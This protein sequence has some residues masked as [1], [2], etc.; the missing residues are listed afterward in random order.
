MQQVSAELVEWLQNEIGRGCRPEV[1]IES[2]IKAGYEADFARNVINASFASLEALE[3]KRPNV[4]GANLEGTLKINTDPLPGNFIKTSDRDVQ[5]LL[6]MQSP[7]IMLF[8]GLLSDEECDG[9]IEFSR[10]KMARSHVVDSDAGGTREDEARTSTG[11]AFQRGETALH[12]RIEK[13]ISELLGWPVEHGE[14][15]QILHYNI[16]GEY[17]PHYDYFHH[18]RP[19]EAEQ[20][21]TGGQRIATLVMY[22]NDVEAGGGTIFPELGLETMPKKG[23]AI[24][25]AYG[26]M[27]GTLDSRSLHGGAPVERGEKW[28]ATKWIRQ[29]PY[30][31]T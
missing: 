10:A 29:R 27:D 28:I 1:L 11:A 20:L 30:Q 31:L 12:T 17:K 5:V 24:Y 6:N 19:G 14:G 8:G 23:N 7:R 21:K 4:L 13:R 26:G 2:M 16:G 25:F 18:D 9:I 15:L 3:G 22:L